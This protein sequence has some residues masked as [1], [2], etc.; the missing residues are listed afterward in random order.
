MSHYIEYQ[1]GVLVE[2]ES[3]EVAPP[4]GVAKA[5]LRD[6]LR[7]GEAVVANAENSFADAIKSG[8]DHVA[9]AVDKAIRGLGTKP[10]EVEVTFGL[11]ATGE[12]GNIAVGKAGAEANI[13]VRLKW[14]HVPEV[15]KH[16]P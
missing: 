4:D 15:A 14:T 9:G 13:Q 11:K 10:G 6:H 1:D 3:D 7:R 12:I 16:A 5:G 8:V 2:V